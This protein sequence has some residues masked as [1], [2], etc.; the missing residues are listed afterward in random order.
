M[1]TFSNTIFI[2]QKITVGRVEH[3]GWQELLK[4]K[5]TENNTGFL[6]PLMLSFVPI[7]QEIARLAQ[8][9][10]SLIV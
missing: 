3:N 7:S 10:K 1:S 8:A 6:F 5:I 4:K 2:Y 9:K